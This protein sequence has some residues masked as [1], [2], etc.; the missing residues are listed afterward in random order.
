MKVR[1]KKFKKPI[2]A[3]EALSENRV[4]YVIGIEA[5]WY[6]LLDDY[7]KPCLYPYKAFL[8]VDPS[9]PPDWTTEYGEDGE[10][11]SY[12][13]KIFRRGFFE[14]YFDRDPKA[15]E[16]FNNYIHKIGVQY[17]A[18]DQKPD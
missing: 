9:E 12:N 8:I 15:I 18:P 17:E 10:R 7:A 16:I 3:F 4:Y 6:R 5:D 14:D 13:R 11:Y 1:L 2:P